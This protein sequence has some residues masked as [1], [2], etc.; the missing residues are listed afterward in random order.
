MQQL[1]VLFLNHALYYTTPQAKPVVVLLHPT[2]DVLE[3]INQK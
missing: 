2:L 3:I 1:S